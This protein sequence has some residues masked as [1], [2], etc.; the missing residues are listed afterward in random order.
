VR[1]WVSAVMP[2]GMGPVKALWW[3]ASE[4]RQLRAVSEDG[5][6]PLSR[7]IDRSSLLSVLPKDVANEVMN[8]RPHADA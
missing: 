7:F 1:S 2:G 6:G 4:A 5:S 8:S 3:R